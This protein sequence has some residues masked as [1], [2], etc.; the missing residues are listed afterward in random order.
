[1]DAPSRDL[2]TTPSP[3]D[4]HYGLEIVDGPEA[5]ISGRLVLGA[6]HLQ[7]TGVVHGGVYAS[8]AEALASHG[9]NRHVAGE[10]RCALGMTN[11]TSFLRPASRGTLHATG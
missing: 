8:I 6:H 9:T 7:P 1:M 11:T 4:D 5:D 2:L 10:G 3:F